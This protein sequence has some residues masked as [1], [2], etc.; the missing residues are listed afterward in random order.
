MKKILVSLA[1][2]V[3]LNSTLLILNSNAQWVQQ[4]SPTTHHLNSIVSVSA[5][6]LYA[7]GE[8]EVVLKTTNGGANWIKLKRKFRGKRLLR[9]VVCE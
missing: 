5:T 4:T 1:V 3:I 9:I 2:I 8:G 6:T 7:S